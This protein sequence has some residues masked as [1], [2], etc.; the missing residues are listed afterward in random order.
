M[1]ERSW[2]RNYVCMS[3]SLSVRHTR[4]LWQNKST[5]CRYFDTTWKGNHSSFLIPT[6]VC[7]R[8]SR[9]LLEICAQSDQPPFEKRRL[10]PIPAYNVRTVRAS[11]RCSI[12]AN[13]KLTTRFPTSYR[14]S[15]YV[16][17]NSPKGWL[18]KRICRF[19]NKIEYNLLQSSF[20]RKLPAAS[21]TI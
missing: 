6:E 16:T 15:A 4:A 21:C 11:E 10:R 2:D 17:P 8:C 19:L 12:I 9:L 20:M 7:G 14:W 18:K 5:Y 3:V 13:R 1:L